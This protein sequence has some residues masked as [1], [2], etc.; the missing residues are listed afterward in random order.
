[1][2][3]DV[4]VQRSYLHTISMKGDRPLNI[5]TPHVELSGANDVRSF[6][7]G[8]RAAKSPV[9]MVQ[10]INEDGEDRGGHLAAVLHGDRQRQAPH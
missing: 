4:C 1:M 2:K 7:G 3:R 6:V 9:A 10:V 5:L 8:D